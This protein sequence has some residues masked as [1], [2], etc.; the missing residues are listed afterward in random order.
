MSGSVTVLFCTC[1]TDAAER[2]ARELVERRLAAC[3]NVVPNL[4]SVYRW[5]GKIQRDT[6]SLLILKTRSERVPEIEAALPEIHP[7]DVPELIALPV[8]QGAKAYLDWV[9]E[10]TAPRPP[11][12]PEDRSEA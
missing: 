6:E 2:I 11:D 10:V 12:A 1:P 9:L 7:Y 3:V 5:K 4:V 8:E